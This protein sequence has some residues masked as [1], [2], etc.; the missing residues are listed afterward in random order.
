MNHKDPDYSKND[1]EPSHKRKCPKRDENND[2]I[3]ENMNLHANHPISVQSEED[4]GLLTA[5]SSKTLSKEDTISQH[6]Q[7]DKANIVSSHY[8]KIPPGTLDS[9]DSKLAINIRK[10]NN[11]IKSVLINKYSENSVLDIACGKGG[12]LKKYYKNNFKEYMGVD[13]ANLSIEEAKNRSRGLGNKMVATFKVQ[14][15]FGENFSLGKKY[16]LVSCQF[17]LHYAF[18]NATTVNTTLSNFCRHASKNIILTIPD[19][20]CLF[21]RKARHGI[22]FGNKFYQCCFKEIE[23]SDPDTRQ[24]LECGCNNNRIKDEEKNYG[25]PYDFTLIDSVKECEEYIINAEILINKL[26]SHGFKM[27]E[28]KNFIDFFNENYNKKREIFKRI[29]HEVSL[30]EEELNVVRLYS[31]LVFKKD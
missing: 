26:E 16:D 31:I 9:R 7:K 14:D 12:D 29:M 8:N 28:H 27:I 3:E 1:A 19:A 10:M 6:P 5:K 30:T 2:I 25:L 23:K 22:E 20:S 17:S 11:F 4:C 24:R 13:I 21:R 15:C 18:I